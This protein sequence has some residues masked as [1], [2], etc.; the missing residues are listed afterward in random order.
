M[1]T[2][3]LIADR[4]MTDGQWPIWSQ[5]CYVKWGKICFKLKI[6][7]K[8]SINWWLNILH[9]VNMCKINIENNKNHKIHWPLCGHVMWSPVKWIGLMDWWPIGNWS[10]IDDRSQFLLHGSVQVLYLLSVPD[11]MSPLTI[12]AFYYGP[13]V[14][15]PVWK[16]LNNHLD[17]AIHV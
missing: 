4:S 1:T 14:L 16:N 3:W 13:K 7:N 6:C 5:F 11:T 12:F 17:T 2:D 8:K 10:V 15:W 9:Y